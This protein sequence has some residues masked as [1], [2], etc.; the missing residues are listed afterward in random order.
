MWCCWGFLPKKNY[1][2][3][4]RAEMGGHVTLDLGVRGLIESLRVLI[5]CRAVAVRV[6][7]RGE[8]EQRRRVS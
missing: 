8:E 3:Q 7:R 6:A 1:T 4:V 2:Q 5:F